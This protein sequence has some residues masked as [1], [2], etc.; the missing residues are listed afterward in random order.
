MA[1][2]RAS[3][4]TPP[5]TKKKSPAPKA[6]HHGDLRRA[7]LDASVA[8]IA[9]R[10][11]EA[12]SLREAARAAG[13]SPAAPYHHFASKSELL[14]AIAA[15]GF[16]GLGA[17]QTAAVAAL[18]DPEQPMAR[19]AALGHAYVGFALAHPTEFRLMFRPSLVAAADLP[20]GCDPTAGFHQLLD[21]VG[22]V[23][24]T[25][26]PGL[27]DERALTLAAWSLVHGAAELVLE[28][29]IG[30]TG[31]RAPVPPGHVGPAVVGVLETLLGVAA[32]SRGA[33]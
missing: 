6:Y 4:A 28:G 2:P 27:L 29:P 19:L 3:G 25:L 10:G 21:A 13:V 1:A 20:A 12:L 26:P 7:L 31:D 23:A 15:R 5:R 9:E 14:G 24:R 8:L 30:A 18:P 11:V 33:E 22:R 16:E 32:K 17:A